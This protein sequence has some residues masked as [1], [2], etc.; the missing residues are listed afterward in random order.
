MNRLSLNDL[1]LAYDRRGSGTPLVLIHGF[2]LDHTIWEPLVPLLEKDC[3]L[4]LPDLRGFGESEPSR[5]PYLLADLAADTAALLDHLKI[6]KAAIA[7]HSMGGYVALAFAHAYPGG[8]SA[9]GWC[10]T[11]G[12]RRARAQGRALRRGR[13]RTGGGRSR[14]GREHVGQADRRPEA[15]GQAEEPDPPAAARRVGSRAACHG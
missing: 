13:A 6:E 15:A 12:G 10:L 5:T 14:R 1:G 4:I 8:R 9:W 2:P 11:T 3:D 7:G